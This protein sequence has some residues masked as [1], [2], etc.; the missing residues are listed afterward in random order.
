MIGRPAGTILS[1]NGLLV[2][3]RIPSMRVGDG[4]R[5]TT[6]TGATIAARVAAVDGRR[7]TLAPFG[8]LE[9]IAAGDRVE[10]DPVALTLVLG[11][12]LLGRACDASG[13]MLD[14]KAAVRGAYAPIE[15]VAALPGARR[16]VDEVFW[17]GVRAIDGPLAFGRGARI[18][19]FGAPGCGKSTLLE[20]IARASSAD[21]TVVGLIGERG[22]EAERWLARVDARTSVI[23]ATS[24]R[25]A[26]E[27]VRAAEAAFAQAQALCARGLHVVLIIDSLAR[28]AAA[29]REVALATG[30][31]AGRGGYPPS[32]FALIA[33]LLER[34]GNFATGSITLIAT[35]LSDGAD[36]REPVSD[37]CRA[38]LDGHIA[39]SPRLAAA[40]WFP[41][42]DLPAS[43]SRTITEVA[44]PEH[45][46]GARALREAVA[47]LEETREARAFGLDPSSDDPM[48]AWAVAAQVK[49]ERF[50]RQDGVPSGP[51]P[52]LTELSVLA[53][54]L[55][56]GYSR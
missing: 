27:R 25:S 23:C 48:L 20:S 54:M 22:R 33:R 6:R 26:A 36:E 13:A 35:V 56:D 37:A 8:P 38:A 40:G 42:I 12:P 51:I 46:R 19:L 44:S 9:G 3:V 1:S 15:S 39:L 11:T 32:V 14:G 30:E 21:A 53:D 2:D 50:L 16:A 52:T 5:I 49:I 41:A 4:A 18:G 47:R 29:A 17:T 55:T 24:D 7:A 31:P 28:V 10:R 45:T 43:A 34:A